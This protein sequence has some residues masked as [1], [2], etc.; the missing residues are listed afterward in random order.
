MGKGDEISRPASRTSDG[1]DPLSDKATEAFVRRTL[2]AHHG[3]GPTV[4]G[5]SFP[6]PINQLLPPLTTSNDVD[7][8]LYAVIAV[9][10]KEFVQT[11]YNKITP[12]H[13]F[14]DEVIHIIAHCTRA[15]E[16]RLRKV[17][18]G[19]LFL[20]EIPQLVDAHLIG[21]S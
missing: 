17:D 14:V 16:Q 6:T 1:L 21:A 2:C 10:L 11:W 4:K 13:T 9:I 12:D 18:L 20:D 5:G 7:L 19:A 15:L 8:Q 3:L